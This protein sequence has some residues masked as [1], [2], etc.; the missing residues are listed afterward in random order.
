M[1]VCKIVFAVAMFFMSC[2]ASTPPVGDHHLVVLKEELS[3]DSVAAHIE[4]VKL[5]HEQYFAHLRLPGGQSYD[6]D[7]NHHR[8]LNMYTIHAPPELIRLLEQ[9]EEIDFVERDR[10]LPFASQIAT[11]GID[12]EFHSKIPKQ[13]MLSLWLTPREMAIETRSTFGLARLSNKALAQAE[14]RHY[15]YNPNNITVPTV[16][17]IDSP[18][19]VDHIEFGGR[20]IFVE[21]DEEHP[22]AKFTHWERLESSFSGHGT[23]MMACILGET[24]GVAR[25]ARGVSIEL[26]YATEGAWLS[27]FV[28]GIDWIRDQSDIDN[29]LKV[30]NLSIGRADSYTLVRAVD[31][32]VVSG[33]HVITS[34]GNDS[35]DMRKVSPANAGRAITVA[36]VD[37]HDTISHFS[38]YGD[39]VWLAAVGEGVY[40]AAIGESNRE[41]TMTQGTSVSSAYVAG[42]VAYLLS[43]KGPTKPDAMREL[44]Q[45]YATEKAHGFDSKYDVKILYNGSGS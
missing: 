23:N 22:Y 14:W 30:I 15:V 45:Q 6:K 29:N 38:N 40:T 7:I 13:D 37:R 17:T 26:F 28:R 24:V 11:P 20:V 21:P 33:I 5:L 43:I 36:S 19:Q 32:A 9:H 39:Q 1:T 18:V 42:V 27:S 35:R 8:Y 34:A 10:V 12:N 31:L 44:L 16:Y 25:A 3:N 2:I 41:Y 4:S